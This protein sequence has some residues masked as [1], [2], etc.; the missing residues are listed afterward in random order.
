MR[1]EEGREGGRREAEME[2]KKLLPSF[3]ALWSLLSTMLWVGCNHSFGHHNIPSSISET[4]F[5]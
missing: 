1:G 3:G 2:G 5:G 4:Q